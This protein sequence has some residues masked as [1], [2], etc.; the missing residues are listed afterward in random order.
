M[1]GFAPPLDPPLHAFLFPHDVMHAFFMNSPT[2]PVALGG[3]MHDYPPSY[4]M[5][6]PSVDGNTVP[7]HPLRLEPGAMTRR[8][9]GGEGDLEDPPFVN[10]NSNWQGPVVYRE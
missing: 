1:A 6:S 8:G 4:N 9:F 2:S 7:I 3:P 5:S 10:R